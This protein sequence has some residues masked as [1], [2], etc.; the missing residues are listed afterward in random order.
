MKPPSPFLEV[1][2]APPDPDPEVERL[3]ASA[4]DVAEPNA[5]NR[6]RVSK[7]LRAA[8]PE[9]SGSALATRG[10]WAPSSRAEPPSGTDR[11]SI[12]ASRPPSRA[13]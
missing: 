7:A 5:E 13:R 6:R 9:L 10:R 11:P 8:L 2:S 4:R 12:V 1:V 3:F